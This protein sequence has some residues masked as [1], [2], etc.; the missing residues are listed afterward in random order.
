MISDPS[1]LAQEVEQ[2]RTTQVDMAQHISDDLNATGSFDGDGE[3]EKSGTEA[4]CNTLH[5]DKSAALCAGG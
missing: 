1:N 3:H 4:P 5:Y 2:G